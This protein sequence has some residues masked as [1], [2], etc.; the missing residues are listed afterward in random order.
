VEGVGHLGLF[1]APVR[2]LD[3]MDEVRASLETA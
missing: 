3:F 2:F 1:E